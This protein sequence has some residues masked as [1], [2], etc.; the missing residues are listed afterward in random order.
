MLG[1]KTTIG[2]CVDSER[3]DGSGQVRSANVAS[4][5]AAVW[6]LRRWLWSCRRWAADERPVLVVSGRHEVLRPCSILA[7]HAR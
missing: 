4:P 1:S 7:G 5:P 3:V 6:T 2:A